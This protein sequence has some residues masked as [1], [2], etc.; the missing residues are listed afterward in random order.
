MDKLADFAAKGV[1]VVSVD[2]SDAASVAA[3]LK[4][5]TRVL[6]ISGSEVGGQPRCAARPSSRPPRPRAAWNSL[7]YTSVA[8]ADTT[9]MSWR[10]TKGNRGAPA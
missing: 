3:A 8:N 6:L 1:R 2:Y 10:T 9:G 7:A 4:G 5:A